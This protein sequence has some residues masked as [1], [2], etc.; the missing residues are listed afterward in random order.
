MIV[1]YEAL[2]AEY[3]TMFYHYHVHEDNAI[4]SWR[5]AVKGPVEFGRL[6]MFDRTELTYSSKEFGVAV[7]SVL[8]RI[9]SYTAICAIGCRA[10]MFK[11]I[12]YHYP[13]MIHILAALFQII[14]NRNGPHQLSKDNFE[15]YALNLGTSVKNSNVS[16]QDK[17]TVRTHVTAALKWLECNESAVQSKVEARQKQ[18]V[19]ACAAILHKVQPA[20][21]KTSKNS[22]LKELAADRVASVLFLMTFVP[23][24]AN[25]SIPFSSVAT[26]DE[27]Q[28]PNSW[29][30]CYK[31]PQTAWYYLFS[32]MFTTRGFEQ[33][34]KV[35]NPSKQVYSPDTFVSEDLFSIYSC[36][37]PAKTQHHLRIALCSCTSTTKQWFVA[38]LLERVKRQLTD[39][40]HQRGKIEQIKNVFA[41][42]IYSECQSLVTPKHE[43]AAGA[44][45]AYSACDLPLVPFH[46][47]HYKFGLTKRSQR[48]VY[49]T[50]MSCNR[51]NIGWDLTSIIMYFV[52]TVSA[53]EL[54]DAFWAQQTTLPCIYKWPGLE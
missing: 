10:Q 27:N 12:A 26:G 44:P 5:Q 18:L 45:F 21:D 42:S 29:R 51:N 22:D 48:I 49:A 6:Q 14:N 28:C 7:S 24:A 36:V 11:C 16:E 8:C 1:N 19:D 54:H 52:D 33:C 38:Q 35:F 39:L 32:Y 46:W 41:R 34:E 9:R 53:W 17:K 25:S 4:V 47:T 3:I 37:A 43:V 20:V 13:H 40:Q 50:Y 31:E 15:L 30:H 2:L 23:S